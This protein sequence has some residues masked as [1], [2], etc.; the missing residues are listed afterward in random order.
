VNE[1]Q[2]VRI[3]ADAQ[4]VLD[5]EAYKAAM[6]GLKDQIVQQ[7]RACP[8]RDAEGA[9]L[10]LQLVK[11][12]DKFDAMLTGMVANGKLTAYEL[13]LNAERNESRTRQFF[14]RVA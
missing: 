11:L 3:G 6:T 8:V 5:N 12:C 13:N 4:Q 2:T 14:R 9:L 7:W 1:H 10:L